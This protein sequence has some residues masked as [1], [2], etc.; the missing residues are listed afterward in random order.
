MDRKWSGLERLDVL[1]AK[2][3]I[4]NVLITSS[5]HLCTEM[6]PRYESHNPVDLLIDTEQATASWEE[7]E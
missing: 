3:M 2:L 1:R 6:R 7:C 4:S 5:M